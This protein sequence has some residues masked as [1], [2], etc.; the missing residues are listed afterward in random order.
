MRF[1]VLSSL[2]FC[3]MCALAATGARADDL[4]NGLALKA[5]IAAAQCTP[6]SNFQETIVSHNA[7]GDGGALTYH[8][9]GSSRTLYGTGPIHRESGSYKGEAWVRDENGVTIADDDPPGPPRTVSVAHGDTPE[10]LVL[11]DLTKSGDGTRTTVDAKTLQVRRIETIDPIHTE[12]TAYTSYATFSGCSMPATWTVTSDLLPTPTTT[13]F[14][15]EHVV[16]GGVT[17]D[18]VAEPPTPDIVTFPSGAARVDIPATFQADGHVIVRANIAGLDA[19]FV[20]DTGS[21]DIIIPQVLARRLGLTLQNPGTTT[22]ARSIAT[23]QAV[24]PVM[25]IGRLEM[26][27]VVV[28]VADTFRTG[29]QG[30][31]LGL[32]GF[33]FFATLEISIDYLHRH[34]SAA[35]GWDFHEPADADATP[36]DIRLGNR[37]PM[38]TATIN[39]TAHADRVIVDTG[40][41][42][43][44]LLFDYF[45]RRHPEVFGTP[46]FAQLMFTGVG[47][48]FETKAFRF[49]SIKL[50][51]LTLLNFDAYRTTGK[52]SYPYAADGL[53]GPEFLRHFTVDF[54]YVHAQMVLR[55]NHDGGL[56]PAAH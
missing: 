24:V 35:S 54:D 56:L 49:Q 22:A 11:S 53:F 3:V 10:T 12:T 48:A 55:E 8:F 25:R 19:D 47:G 31:E 43:D 51:R 37:V 1:R 7:G 40:G 17:A 41:A 50:G 45:N 30:P 34:V 23:S 15:R 26:H 2:C 5:Q 52:Q 38:I 36:I 46:E 6:A 18:L 21:S 27:D 42:G 14:A 28:T 44:L 13:T 16:V 29:T 33:D 32:L 9:D 39:G 4:P 20:L